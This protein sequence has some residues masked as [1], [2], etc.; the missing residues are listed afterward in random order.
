MLEGGPLDWPNVTSCSCTR[1]LLRDT[2]DLKLSRPRR[3]FSR[4]Y[5]NLG[6]TPG[7]ERACVCAWGGLAYALT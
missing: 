5:R 2:R 4:S 7:G 1:S 3:L 6:V